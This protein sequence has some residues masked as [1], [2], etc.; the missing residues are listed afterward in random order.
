MSTV[1]P[2]GSSTSQDNTTSKTSSVGDLD[3]NAFLKLLIEQLKNQDPTKPMDSTAFVAQLATFSQVEQIIQS[4]N[5]LDSLLTASA[6]SIADA[7]IGHTV[8][9]SDG[10][11]TGTVASVKITSDGPLAT[12]TNGST[13]LLGSGIVMQ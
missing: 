3:Y 12:L 6:L 1:P 11:T 2:V 8:T 5:K 13:V 9:S 7:V 10:L 4:N